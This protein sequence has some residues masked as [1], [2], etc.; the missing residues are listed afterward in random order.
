MMKSIRVRIAGREY[1]LRVQ[2]E[3]EQAMVRLAQMVDERIEDFKQKHQGHPD[4]VAAV[5]VAL[6][7]AEELS[8]ARDTSSVL[9]SALD[10]EV[11]ILDRE[12]ASALESERNPS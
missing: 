2:A 10:Q 12:L 1:P 9:L 3:D 8:A 7:L 11:A 5:V 4:V 6:G